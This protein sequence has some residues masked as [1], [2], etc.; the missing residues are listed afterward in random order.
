MNFLKIIVLTLS[1]FG[2][3]ALAQTCPKNQACYNT[4]I[5]EG[6]KFLAVTGDE[7]GYAYYASYPGYASYASYPGQ[8]L[9]HRAN[10]VCKFLG[11]NTAAFAKAGDYTW[12]D[13][14]EVGRSGYARVVTASYSAKYPFS[15]LN[16]RQ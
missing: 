16:C 5:Y 9:K 12:E 13:L 6:Y 15:T 14:L 1:L 3:L 10:N 7:A 8:V 11:H 2:Q 4:P